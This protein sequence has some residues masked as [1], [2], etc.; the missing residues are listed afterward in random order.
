MLE[1]REGPISREA[2]VSSV[3]KRFESSAYKQLRRSNPELGEDQAFAVTGGGKNQPGRGGSRHGSGKPGGLQVGRGNGGSGRGRGNGGGSS[4]GGAS[5]GSNSTA[6]AKPGGGCAGCARATRITS[7]T[8]PN[9]SA[10]VWREGPLHNQVRKDGEC[11]DGGRHAWQ[12]VNGRRL[13]GVLQSRS[14]DIHHPRNQD[15]RV[16]GFNDGGG[17]NTADEGRSLAS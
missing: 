13:P 11:G 5:S 3:Q 4:G 2:V 8:T 16:F 1:E 17:I 6:T 14:R 15:S 7:V 9:R 12:S 10:R